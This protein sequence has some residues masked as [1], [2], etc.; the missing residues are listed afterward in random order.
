MLI[1]REGLELAAIAV[2]DDDSRFALSCIQVDPQ[3]V[4]TVSD[5]KVALRMQAAVDEPSLFDQLAEQDT[6]ELQEPAMVPADVAIAFLAGMK[7]RKA[8]PG[9]AT[10]H[11]VVAQQDDRLTMRSSDGS[12]TRTFVIENDKSG[13]AFP[14]VARIFAQHQA[15]TRISLG[16]DVVLGV[17]RVLK[18][19]KVTAFTLDVPADYH[20]AN[21]PIA[22]SAFALAGPIAGVIM[23]MR[24]GE[25]IDFGWD[26]W[27]STP[28]DAEPKRDPNTREMFTDDA[29][30]AIASIRKMAA[31]DGATISIVDADGTRTVIADGRSATACTHGVDIT[32]D[33]CEACEAEA[34]SDTATVVE[35]LTRKGFI[36]S[37]SGGQSPADIQAAGARKGRERRAKKG[38]RR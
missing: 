19:C 38:G 34:K 37:T 28:P 33:T 26:S 11:V 20:E 25:A 13:A 30:E 4:V 14:N 21:H 27:A 17:L 36:E 7:K 16:V 29:S 24:D 35:N 3:G 2:T 23:P 32:A 10:P 1:H 5:G 22:L 15:G 9:E 6:D 31:E 8:K 18:A 12:A